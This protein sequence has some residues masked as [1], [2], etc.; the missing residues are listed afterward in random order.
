MRSPAIDSLLPIPGVVL[1]YVG[2]LLQVD[3]FI[4]ELDYDHPISNNTYSDCRKQFG[5]TAGPAISGKMPTG[6]GPF[7]GLTPG[8]LQFPGRP[9]PPP[10]APPRP[11]Q[12]CKDL[13][14][15]PGYVPTS[16][17]CGAK[18]GIPF[19]NLFR[20]CCDG[21]DIAYGTCGQSKQG[22]DTAF[23][24]CILLTCYRYQ[25]SRTNLEICYALAYIHY[26]A[27][28]RLGGSAYD[29]GQNTA[30]ICCDEGRRD[31]LCGPI[32]ILTVTAISLQ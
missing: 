25:R 8:P 1:P 11:V 10:P 12:G 18:D 30:C 16:N 7:P 13:R 9:I 29:A 3:F 28:H 5:N 32:I 14:P 4:A 24:G 21:H 26:S 2:S 27:V 22:A 17:G 20:S 6:P 15:R 23:L 31:P 19:P